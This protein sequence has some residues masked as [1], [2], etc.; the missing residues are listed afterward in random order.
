MIHKG[1]IVP[2]VLLY[3]RPADHHA[4]RN[5]IVAPGKIQHDVLLFHMKTRTALALARLASQ[6]VHT[7]DLMQK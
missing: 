1:D 4:A 2:S 7:Q 6:R 3:S 5:K